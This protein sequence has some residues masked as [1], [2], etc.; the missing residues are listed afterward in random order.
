MSQICTTA[1]QRPYSEK[2]EEN[3]MAYRKSR[4]SEDFGVSQVLKELADAIGKAMGRSAE[5][6]N[7]V[8]GLSLYQNTTP[9]VPN[10][11]TY[12]RRFVESQPWL[13]AIPVN[14]LANRMVVGAL[15]T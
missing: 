15:R 7:V 13:R 2:V 8:P 1:A 12:E 5:L 14:E 4:Q 10:P 11:C 3:S 9:T 6:S